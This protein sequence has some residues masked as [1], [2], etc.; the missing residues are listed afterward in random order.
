[1]KFLSLLLIPL[2]TMSNKPPQ[3]EHLIFLQ[4]AYFIKDAKQTSLFQVADHPT[5]PKEKIASKKYCLD[6]EALKTIELK[7]NMADSLKEIILDEKNYITEAQKSCP[8]TAKY[9]I[10]FTK[11]NN[12]SFTLI[13]S[14][15]PCEKVIVNCSKKDFKKSYFD[16]KE[17]SE[18]LAFIEKLMV[19]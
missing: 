14:T 15:A 18:I 2:L 7:E 3:D 1:M 10:T 6:Y 17:K 4:Y 8:M 5:H 13:F 16:L 12:Q 9:A 19:E 11:K